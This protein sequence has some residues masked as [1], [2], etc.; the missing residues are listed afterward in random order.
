M[1]DTEAADEN[2]SVSQDIFIKLENAETTK[3]KKKRVSNRKK[4]N[5]QQFEMKQLLYELRK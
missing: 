2:V 5:N 3:K 1:S 4:N